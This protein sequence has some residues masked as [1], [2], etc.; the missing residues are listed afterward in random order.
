MKKLTNINF[1]GIDY[2]QLSA[3]SAI[4]AKLLKETLTKRTLIKILK[5]DVILNDCVIYSAY[6]KWFD[7]FIEEVE[8]PVT[9]QAQPDFTEPVTVA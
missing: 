6:E 9:E 1:K 4:Q 8:T 7:S 5:N 2:I 3:L